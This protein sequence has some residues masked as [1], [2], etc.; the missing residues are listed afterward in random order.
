MSDFDK[1][2]Q[3]IKES[4]LTQCEDRDCSGCEFDKKSPEAGEFN[5]VNI[6][7]LLNEVYRT[8]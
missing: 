6:C 2:K 3:A 7:V 1:I 8:N 5:N 4:G